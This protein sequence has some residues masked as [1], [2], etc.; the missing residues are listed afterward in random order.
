MT[1]YPLIPIIVVVEDASSIASNGVFEFKKI[2]KTIKTSEEAQQFANAQLDAYAKSLRSGSFNTYRAGLSSGQ[3]ITANLA[4]LGVVDSFTIQRVSFEMF[5]KNAGLWQVEVATQRT[6]GIIS[7]LQ[8]LLLA[9]AD[10]IVLNDN[11]VLEKSYVNSEQINVTEEITLS[12]II[13]NN[14]TVNVTEN[15]MVDPFGENTAPNFVLAPH[16][17]TGQTDRDREFI[18][19]GSYLS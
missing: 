16:V 10:E 5:S 3:T 17:V 4:S 18:L 2:N 13:S 12:T 15:I 9:S 11:E 8:D 6:T 1:G 14:E 19:D 7:F